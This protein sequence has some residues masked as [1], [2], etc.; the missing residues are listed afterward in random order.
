MQL[1][2]GKI[3][4]WSFSF[5][6]DLTEMWFSFD[7]SHLGSFV[8]S[9]FSLQS[10]ALEIRKLQPNFL[11]RFFF[12]L[13]IFISFWG[14]QEGED[15]EGVEGRRRRRRQRVARGRPEHKEVEIIRRN[16][17]LAITKPLQHI[18]PSTTPLLSG[19]KVFLP[20]A[21]SNLCIFLMFCFFKRWSS[22][23]VIRNTFIFQFYCFNVNEILLFCSLTTFSES[24]G[25]DFYV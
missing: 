25:S 11:F 22:S 23:V 1:P 2:K 13:A 17:C 7:S 9:S 24:C 6:L 10:G 21:F 16:F 5:F 3:M 20:K 12:K 4:L 8:K 18:V 14:F 19:S 15:E